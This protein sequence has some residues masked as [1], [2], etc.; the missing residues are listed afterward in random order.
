MAVYGHRP[1]PSNQF[2][3]LMFKLHHKRKWTIFAE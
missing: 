3:Y 1:D 2:I